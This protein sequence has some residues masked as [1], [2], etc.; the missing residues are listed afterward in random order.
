MSQLDIL[1]RTTHRRWPSGSLK[2]GRSLHVIRL[3]VCVALTVT[4]TGPELESKELT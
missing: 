4:V 2:D 1:Q 3:S